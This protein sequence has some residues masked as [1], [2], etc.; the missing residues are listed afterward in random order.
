M[1]AKSKISWTQHV[2]NPI[3]GCSHASAGCKNCYAEKMA[4][5]LEHNFNTPQ[6]AGTT[7][8]QTH[9]WTGKINLAPDRTLEAPLNRKKPT[10]Y[11]VNSM[12]DVFHENVPDGWIDKIISIVVRCPHH[13]FILLTKRPARMMY[14]MGALEVKSIFPMDEDL[15]YSPSWPIANLVV[16]ASVENMDCAH[17]RMLDLINTPAACRIVSLEPQLE[18]IDLTMW[19]PFIDGVIQG[20]ESGHN[21]RPFKADWARIMRNQC[22]VHSDVPYFLK[23]MPDSNGKVVELPLLDGR[24]HS[25]LPKL[26]T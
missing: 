25:Q 24:Q 13:K 2:W 23:Q 11:F 19:L 18:E 9:K 22:S 12:S 3:V 7:N 10:T 6:Y 17:A 26:L 20:C 15:V 21:R 14:Y 5:R 8:P 16:G 4:V 1:M